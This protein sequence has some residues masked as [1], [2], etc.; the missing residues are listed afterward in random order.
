MGRPA[1]WDLDVPDLPAWR[2]AQLACLQTCPMLVECR[3]LLAGHYPR[4]GSVAARNPKS[5]IWAG[6]AYGQSGM[7]LSAAALPA[8]AAAAATSRTREA[9]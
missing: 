6:V 8:V 4:H 1:A 7:I 3:R 5:V 9:A 2:V